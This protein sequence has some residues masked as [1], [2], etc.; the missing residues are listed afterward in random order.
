MYSYSYNPPKVEG[1]DDETGESL[2]QREDDKPE[3][4][5]KRLKK[6]TEVCMYMYVL[7]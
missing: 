2:I 3:S 1:K 4:V 5:Q 7:Y 6:Y